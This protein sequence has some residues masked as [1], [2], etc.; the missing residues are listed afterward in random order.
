[1][2]NPQKIIGSI[3]IGVLIITSEIPDGFE[4]KSEKTAIKTKLYI[5]ADTG[6]DLWRIS[7]LVMMLYV[8]YEIPAPK[9]KS[10]PFKLYVIPPITPDTRHDPVITRISEINFTF[11]NFSPKKRT[12]YIITK[13]GAVYISTTAV[14]TEENVIDIK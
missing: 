7:I 1:M 8:L 3:E 12:E 4:N 10:I 13:T 9:P 11:V 14:D 5:L 6:F 2:H